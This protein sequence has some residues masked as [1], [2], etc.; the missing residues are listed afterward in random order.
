MPIFVL[1]HSP[2]V[3]P[4]TWQPV[5]DRLRDAGHEVTV[6]SLLSVGDGGAP[7]WPRVSSAVRAGLAG[8]DPSQPV[9]LVPHSNAG[10]FVPVIARDLQRPVACSV[11]ADAGVPELSGS[12]PVVGADF[13]PFLRGLA[14]EDGLLPRTDWWD[15]DDIVA[16]LPDPRVRAIITEEQPRLPLDYYLD[17]VPAPAGWDD[18][19]CGYL[20]FSEGYEGQADEARR[21]GWPVRTTPGEHLHQVRRPG[22]GDA[23]TAGTGERGG[24]SRPRR[25]ALRPSLPATAGSAGPG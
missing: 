25:S 4:A 21:R 15:S 24:L 10:L 19:P 3:G 5:A 11:F 20:L 14:D 13:L 22:R 9:V 2:S 7:F 17:R 1:I 23:G 18:H 12:T 8:T 16:M 6:P